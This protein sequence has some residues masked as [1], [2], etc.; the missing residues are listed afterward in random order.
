MKEA[1]EIMSLLAWDSNTNLSVT[2]AR[3]RQTY[4]LYCPLPTSWRN[5]LIFNTCAYVR[6][7]T[8]GSQVAQ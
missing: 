6:I 8:L 7:H 4:L 2:Q 5:Y 1:L 3:H